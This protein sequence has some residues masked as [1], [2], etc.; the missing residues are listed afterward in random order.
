MGTDE[1]RW[2]F[3]TRGGRLNLRTK[4]RSKTRFI[5]LG[6]IAIFTLCACSSKS[7][8]KPAKAPPKSIVSSPS[9][10][11]PQTHAPVP[12]L[13]LSHSP[14]PKTTQKRVI[15]QSKTLEK[16]S[17]PKSTLIPKAYEFGV[18]IPWE[19]TPPEKLATPWTAIPPAETTQ[20]IA[21]V[22][23]DPQTILVAAN[24]GPTR[25]AFI[26]KG[27]VGFRIQ[28]HD[29]SSTGDLVW[30][31]CPN[32]NE[33]MVGYFAA[34]KTWNSKEHPGTYTLFPLTTVEANCS[35]LSNNG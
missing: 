4:S 21:V 25:T 31:K 32:G 23:V 30:V 12:R 8:E 22:Q 33:D 3:F 7:M 11:V 20:T 15:F 14:S 26:V 17:K 29:A 34:Y 2:Y 27:V 35:G 5:I 16:G 13:S 24:R 1:T 6:L 19:D 10:L 18:P 28:K 9:S